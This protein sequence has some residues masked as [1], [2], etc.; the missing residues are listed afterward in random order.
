MAH[1]SKAFMQQVLDV[2]QLWRNIDAEH[3]RQKDDFGRRFEAT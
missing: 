1:V 2:S 3:P